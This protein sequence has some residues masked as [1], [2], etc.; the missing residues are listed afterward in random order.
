MAVREVTD[1]VN[2]KINENNRN[3][4]DFLFDV[5]QRTIKTETFKETIDNNTDMQIGL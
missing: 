4:K 5:D 2:F 1:E 3:V